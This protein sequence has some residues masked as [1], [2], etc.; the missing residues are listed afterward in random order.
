MDEGENMAKISFEGQHESLP[1]I[2]VAIREEKEEDLTYNKDITSR[3][4][5]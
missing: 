4:N 2:L 1:S 5:E 3:N